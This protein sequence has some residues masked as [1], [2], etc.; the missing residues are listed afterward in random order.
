MTSATF[1]VVPVTYEYKDALAEVV[2]RAHE[3]DADA[4][5]YVFDH[6]FYDVY[7]E[8]FVA[9]RDRRRAERVTRKAFNR[10]P[11]MLR[12]GRYRTLDELREAIAKDALGSGSKV[13]ASHPSSDV[14]GLRA[15]TRHLVLVSAAAVAAAGALALAI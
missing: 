5:E 1:P 14:T 8:V 6:L 4:L 13:R 11:S 2:A 10:L 3:G 15:A 7:H 9:S 12:S